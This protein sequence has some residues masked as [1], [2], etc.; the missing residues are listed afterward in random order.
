M[1]RR[2]TL[3]TCGID[4]EDTVFVRRPYQAPV[5]YH[6]IFRLPDRPGE[7]VLIPPDC[8]EWLTY[9]IAVDD[10][11]IFLPNAS[12]KELCQTPL[13]RGQTLDITSLPLSADT[14]ELLCAINTSAGIFRLQYPKEGYTAALKWDQTML[15]HCLI[16]LS[17]RGR[18]A[19]PWRGKNL[20]IGVE[21]VASAFD[22]GYRISTETNPMNSRGR[23][24]YIAFDPAA[25]TKFLHSIE[26]SQLDLG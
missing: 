10:G 16:W 7:C 19:E 6:P 12:F 11:S 2:V 18:K 3:R 4:F 14:E 21:P 8:E 1:E 25:P 24:T 20:C 5:G 15:P 17:N 26:V 22:L 9:P 23:P 13:A